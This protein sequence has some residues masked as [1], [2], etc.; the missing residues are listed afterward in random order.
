LTDKSSEFKKRNIKLLS[1]ASDSM[2]LLQ[3]FREENNFNVDIISDR[4]AKLA[5]DYDVYWFAPGGG[6]K[7]NVKQAVP[8]KFLISKDGIII[9]TYIGKD[10]TDRPPI[11]LMTKVIDE[12]I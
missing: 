4:G 1:I 11:E 10:K 2:H 7:I 5:K 8:S 9:W 12:K 3:K 6:G